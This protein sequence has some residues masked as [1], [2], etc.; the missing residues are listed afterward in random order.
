MRPMAILRL[1]AAMFVLGGASK[2]AEALTLVG[3]QVDGEIRFLATPLLQG[4]TIVSDPGGLELFVEH[5][6]APSLTTE[7]AVDIGPS[8]VTIT[9]Q[10]TS[11]V[12]LNTLGGGGESY[13]VSLTDLDWTDGPSTIADVQVIFGSVSVSFGADEIHVTFPQLTLDPGQIVTAQLQIVP[14]PEPGTL[15]LLA[16]GVAVLAGSRRTRGRRA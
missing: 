8:S 10:N 9:V 11:A 1:A 16:A 7:I 3:D 13:G 6:I 4:F 15:A 5:V 12:T 14:V 2:P